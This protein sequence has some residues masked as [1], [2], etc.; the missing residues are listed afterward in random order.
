MCL[1]LRGGF[2]GGTAEDFPASGVS[3]ESGNCCS[4]SEGKWMHYRLAIPADSHAAAILKTTLNSLR[5]DKELQGTFSGSI[6]RDVVRTL[7]Y[8]SWVRHCRLCLP[9]A[10]KRTTAS[11][12]VS[13]TNRN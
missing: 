13:D 6:R 7:S 3:A 9:D 10:G 12:I 5:Q 2:G 4:E 11:G 8:D 1:L